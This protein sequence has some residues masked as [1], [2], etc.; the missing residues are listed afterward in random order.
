[1][2]HHVR[3]NQT[4]RGAKSMDG[5]DPIFPV[6][7]RELATVPNVSPPVHYHSLLADVLGSGARYREFITFHSE[8]LYPEYLIAYQRFHGSSGPR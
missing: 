2:G 8:Y 7:F 3:T 4:G 6:S 5:G 1:M